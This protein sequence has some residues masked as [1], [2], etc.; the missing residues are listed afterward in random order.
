LEIIKI[1]CGKKYLKEKEM[2]EVISK[3]SPKNFYEL[4]LNTLS[5]LLPESFFISWRDHIPQKSL[6]F[7]IVIFDI[8]INLY[9]NINMGIIEKYKKLGVIKKFETESFDEI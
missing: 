6:S 5:G 7:I 2:F 1:V 3:Y 8:D 4:K 9:V